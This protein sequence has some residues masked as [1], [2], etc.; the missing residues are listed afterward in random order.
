MNDQIIHN[1]YEFWK[2]IGALNCGLIETAKYSA[3]SMAHSDW[4]TRI[5]NLQN[6][7][8]SI[9]EIKHLS[10]KNELP[11]TVTITSPND[12]NRDADFEF[13]FGQ[14]NMAFDLN[15]F[16]MNSPQ[17]LN[18]KRVRTVEE[19]IE[20]ANTASASFGYRVNPDVIIQ[21]V[22]KSKVLRLFTYQEHCECLGCGSVFFDAKHNA[23]L[24]MIGTLPKSRAKGIGKR[25][26]ESLL[27]EA[28]ASNANLCVLNASFMGEPLY[29]GLGFKPYGKIETYRLL[30]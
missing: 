23:G 24:H 16:S 7:S 11:D 8:D 3:V 6:D 5:F 22:K 14:T 2:H 21:L 26:T 13:V 27:M 19:S 25:M 30:K 18:V 28:K 9:D 29:T 4:P 10:K 12:L 20:F 1:L 15:F 17:D